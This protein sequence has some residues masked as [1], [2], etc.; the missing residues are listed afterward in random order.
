[1]GVWR[2]LRGQWFRILL[3]VLSV[4][5]VGGAVAV[6]FQPAPAAGRPAPLPVAANEYEVVW[7]YAAT[8]TAAWERFV[9][10]VQ[11]TGERLRECE[12]NL[13]VE[14][15]PAAFPRQ[16]TAVPEVALRWRDSGTRL[17]FRWYKLTSDWK[18]RD[19][20]EALARR[21]PPPLAVIGGSSSDGAREVAVQLEQAGRA[22]PEKSRPLLLLTTASADKVARDPAAG[23]PVDGD[24]DAGQVELTRLYPGRTFRYCFTNRQMAA[25]IM[26][27][28]L[29]DPNLRPDS[30]PIYTV[31]W[32]DDSYSRDLIDGFVD[33]LQK[34]I[35]ARSVAREW[36]WRAGC[37][38]QGAPP[39]PLAGGLLLPLNTDEL[40]TYHHVHSS[41]GTFAT[42]NRFEALVARFLLDEM[43]RHPQQ[44]RPLLIVSG[45]SQPSRRFLRELARSDPDRA[46][47]LVVATGDTLAF[48]TVYRDHTTLWPI[49]DL[50]FKLVFF[51]HRNPID[52]SGFDPDPKRGRVTGTE[53]LLLFGDIVETLALAQHQGGR[54]C[55]DAATLAGRL[56]AI[57]WRDGDLGFEEGGPRL[58]GRSGN[59]RSGTGEHV[60]S[61]RP[62][63]RGER[64]LPGATI[65]VWERRLEDRAEPT[66]ARR[67]DPLTVHYG[68]VP[69]AGDVP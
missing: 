17:V 42:P 11:R 14:V 55:G 9:A 40:S 25:A 3:I 16:T 57:T 48:N 44:R 5:L 60:V 27:F 31:R 39:F 41:V 38:G 23:E 45:Q 21:D 13:E 15:G 33:S 59:R 32:D 7:L 65:E 64:V 68:D 37:L 2:H 49:Q 4:G 47:Q 36:A 58:F 8:N 63:T 22:L 30:R 69:G 35:L 26:Q 10:A 67:G 19:W 46:R 52:P 53:D 6:L 12:P 1:M 34:R 43:D 51:C 56:A 66:W 29:Q 18:T 24:A 62:H 20:V 61:L 50:P 28:I 54:P